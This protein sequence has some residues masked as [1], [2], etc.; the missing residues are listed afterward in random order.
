[1]PKIQ[2]SIASMEADAQR[3]ATLASQSFVEHSEAYK[4]SERRYKQLEREYPELQTG[5]YNSKF[6]AIVDSDASR[7]NAIRKMDEAWDTYV[8][9][10]KELK[11]RFDIFYDIVD[12]SDGTRKLVFSSWL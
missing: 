4:I 8:K 9:S 1:M 6:A 3:L 7:L 11:E 2:I 10:S 5:P 12:V